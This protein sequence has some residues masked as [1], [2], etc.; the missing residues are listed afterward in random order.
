MKMRK[1]IALVLVVLMAVFAFAGC[2][3]KETQPPQQQQQ[4][5]E[6]KKIKVGLVF[7]VG[8][9]GDLSFNDSAYAGLERAQK[10]FGDKI[11]VKYLEP[12][13]G[14][15]NRE[16]LLRLL[17]EDGYNLIFGVGFMFTDHIAKVS[18][19]FP[20]VK[21]GLIDG[22]IE[23]LDEKSNVACLQFKE[24]E[25]SFL[26]GAAAALKS[27]T[28]KI[29][30]VGG[31]KI[32]LIEK[33]EAG[34]M[35][36]AK[37]ANPKVEI[38]SD[39]IGTTG[40]AFKDPVKG[41]ELALKQFKAGADV[42]YHASGA[43]GIGVIEAATAEKKF[44]IGVDSDQSLTAKEEQRPYILTSMLKR[45]DVAVYDTIK[46]YVEGNFKGGYRVFGL[47]EDGVGY[48][49]NDYNKNM[50]S[51]ITA[52]LDELKGKIVKGEIKVPADKK[53]YEEFVKGLK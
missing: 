33:F 17:A 10:E 44:A 25:G 13:A 41:K 50:I 24:E 26:V 21:F 35:A 51:D 1:I 34:Y 38:V 39:Y 30:F 4:P 7:D 52:K 43:S 22:F 48:A 3:K 31:M 14:G 29:G 49:L 28:G 37:Y 12:S 6:T 53:Q 5:A 2:A 45:V 15:E 19:E 23:G 27:K 32:P 42:V 36:G 18:K 11:E 16:Q 46:D 20:D 8:G 40:E 9:R 47:A